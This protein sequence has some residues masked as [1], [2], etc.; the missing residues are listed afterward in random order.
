MIGAIT[1]GLYGVGVS[2]TPTT[3]FVSIATAV[4]TGS[5]GIITFT[6][7][8]ST[9]KHLQIRGIGRATNTGATGQYALIT[10]NGD[11]TSANYISHSIDGNGSAVGAGSFTGYAGGIIQR[12]A[13]SSLASGIMGVTVTDVLD[14]TSTSKNKAMRTLGGLD[15][16]TSFNA[17][18]YMVSN[19]WISTAAITS[20]TI[21]NPSG[22][23]DSTTSFALYGIQGA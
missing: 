6:A 21:T 18:I 14:Y 8:P 13:S 10:A 15:A 7:I 16:N 17:G 12:Y 1:A 2:P 23:W 5:S 22:N 4:G 9:Y 11:S 19:L 3:G 20:L